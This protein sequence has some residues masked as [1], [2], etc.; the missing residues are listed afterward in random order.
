MP[1]GSYFGNCTR[2]LCYAV[3]HRFP[4]EEEESY[5]CRWTSRPFSVIYNFHCV[6]A[7]KTALV[8]GREFFQSPIF[9]YKSF[10]FGM[11]P[12]T[13]VYIK[14]CINYSNVWYFWGITSHLVLNRTWDGRKHCPTSNNNL[15]LIYQ[16]KC[17]VNYYF[18]N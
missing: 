17:A 3:A 2:A 12:A 9:L 15:F 4:E 11:D 18:L 16:V 13:R 14:I 5:T 10:L 1:Q 7:N 8:L 6:E